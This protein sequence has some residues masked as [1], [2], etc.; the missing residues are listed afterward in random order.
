[1]SGSKMTSESLPSRRRSKTWSLVYR[2][3]QVQRAPT[4]DNRQLIV[5]GRCAAKGFEPARFGERRQD[6]LVAGHL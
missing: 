3:D 5:R 4:P 1:M 2:E 6:T